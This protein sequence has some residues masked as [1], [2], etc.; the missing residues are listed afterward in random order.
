MGTLGE[1]DGVPSYHRRLNPGVISTSGY[2]Q[3]Q[4]TACWGVP[5]PLQEARD[6]LATIKAVVTSLEA[7]AVLARSQRMKSDHWCVGQWAFVSSL[8]FLVDVMAYSQCSFVSR[9]A[10]GGGV[11]P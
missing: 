10:R 11:P 6:E 2:R 9:A 8:C 1:G 5:T 4:H 7:E 3:A